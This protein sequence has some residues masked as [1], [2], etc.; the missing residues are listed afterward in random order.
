MINYKHICRNNN[1]APMCI[2]ELRLGS[3]RKTK[4]YFERIMPK[5][6]RSILLLVII[7]SLFFSVDH[8]LHDYQQKVDQ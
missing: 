3:E 2:E 8:I 6:L 1:F 7:Y 4:A 5:H